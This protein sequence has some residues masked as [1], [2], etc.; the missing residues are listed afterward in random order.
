ML[1]IEEVF[2]AG[3]GLKEVGKVLQDLSE[4]TY[5]PL[6]TQTL[7]EVEVSSF[8]K[9]LSLSDLRRFVNTRHCDMVQVNT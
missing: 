7:S 3:Q 6:T 4:F 2:E 1:D 8:K 5:S 9:L